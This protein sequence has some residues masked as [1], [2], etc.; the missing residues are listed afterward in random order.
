MKRAGNL[1]PQLIGFENLLESATAAARGKRRRPLPREKRVRA[2]RRFRA[3]GE[4]YD[5]GELDLVEVRQRVAAWMG[6]AAFGER[7]G[8][9]RGL[10]LDPVAHGRATARGFVEQQR[11]ELAGGEP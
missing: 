11:N 5:R 10:T 7:G 2:R 9:L 3:I 8:V 1:W 6:H 4:R